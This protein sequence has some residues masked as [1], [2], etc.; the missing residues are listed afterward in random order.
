ML[1]LLTVFSR[2]D[3]EERSEGPHPNSEGGQSAAVSVVRMQ[4]SDVNVSQH[5]VECPGVVSDD[6][7]YLHQVEQELSI[8]VFSW[9]RTP[10]QVDECGGFGDSCSRGVDGGSRG[11]YKCEQLVYTEGLTGAAVGTTSVSS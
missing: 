7:C 3:V 6:L 5:S 4:R 2:V 8:E 10:A 1:F 11:D 9:H